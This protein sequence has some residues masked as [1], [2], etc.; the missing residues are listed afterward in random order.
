M[1][2]ELEPLIGQW[3][4]HFDKGQRFFVVEIEEVEGTV[5]IQHFD[6]N[7]EAIS[8]D[9][10]HDL[11]IELSEE[12]ENWTGALDMAEDDDLGAGVTDTTSSDWSEPSEDYRQPNK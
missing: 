4:A 10:W 9:E 11:D 1:L 12:P 8:F 6:G 7:I 5:E 2:N 3:Y